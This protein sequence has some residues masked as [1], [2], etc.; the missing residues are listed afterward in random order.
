V[1]AYNNICAA[2]NQL[3]EYD[4]AIEACNKAIE[5]DSNHSLAKGN[6]NFAISQNKLI[7][8]N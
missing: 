2:Y 3:K 1:A 8:S 7:S 6:L 5:L 4:K